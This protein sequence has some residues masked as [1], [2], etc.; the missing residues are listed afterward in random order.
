VPAEI[1]SG[2]ARLKLA[3]M[4]VQIDELTPDQRTYLASWDQGT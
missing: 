2:I 3:S 1:D 4:D